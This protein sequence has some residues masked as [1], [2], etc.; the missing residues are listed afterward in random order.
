LIDA[1][2]VEDNPTFVTPDSGIYTWVELGL[3][4]HGDNAESVFFDDFAIQWEGIF[5]VGHGTGFLPPIQQ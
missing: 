3:N 5:G 1:V 2:I 4:T